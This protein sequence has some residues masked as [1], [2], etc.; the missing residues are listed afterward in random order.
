MAHDNKVANIIAG[1]IGSRA[2]KMMGATNFLAGVNYLQFKIGKNS[3]G[4]THITI[5]LCDDDTYQVSFDKVRA[6]LVSNIDIA[7]DV[8]AES[9]NQTIELYTNMYL[10]L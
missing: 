4:V 2:F 7:C 9:L 6:R 5:T 3:K 8:Y 10:S 1:Q